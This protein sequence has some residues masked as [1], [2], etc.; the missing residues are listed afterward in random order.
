MWRQAGFRLALVRP[1]RYLLR[2]ARA[3]TTPISFVI[4]GARKRVR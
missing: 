4:V 3:T 2:M 1:T